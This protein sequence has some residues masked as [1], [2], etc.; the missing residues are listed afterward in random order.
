MEIVKS[1]T[2][3]PSTSPPRRERTNS[4]GEARPIRARA[5]ETGACRTGSVE[6]ISEIDFTQAS[7]GPAARCAFRLFVCGGGKSSMWGSALLTFVE[8]TG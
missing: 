6:S 1:P 2:S 4:A 7:E 3:A 5:N 8:D